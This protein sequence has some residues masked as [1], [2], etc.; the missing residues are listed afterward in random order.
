MDTIIEEKRIYQFFRLSVLLKGAHSILEIIGGL[1]LFFISPSVIGKFVV[2][3]T[4]DELLEDS[5]D[6]VANYLLHFGTELSIGSVL[7]GALYLFAHGLIK[8]LLVVALLKNK[9]WAYPW[10]RTVLALFILYQ[11]YRFSFTHS[12]ALIVLTLFDLIVIWLIW[13][14]YQIVRKHLVNHKTV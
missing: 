10:S 14:E 13:S 8:L 11:I 6:L 4:Q 7:F 1:L 9:L 3:I 2:W 5:H 12:P